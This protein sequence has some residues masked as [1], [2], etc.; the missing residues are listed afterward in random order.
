[1]SFLYYMCIGKIQ[2][3]AKGFLDLGDE[4]ITVSQLSV[5][6][7]DQKDAYFYLCVIL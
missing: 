4:H 1:M 2:L 3:H 6:C 5:K 7:C